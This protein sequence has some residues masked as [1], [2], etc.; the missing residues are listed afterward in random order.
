MFHWL[1]LLVRSSRKGHAV[2]ETALIAPWI[3]FLFVGILDFGFYA[4]GL[5]S[6][7]NAAR[8]A[9]LRAGSGGGTAN[10]QVLA[11]NLARQELRWMPNIKNLAAPYTCAS[12]PLK[13]DV[14]TNPGYTDAE[15]NPATWVQVTYQTVQLIPIPG[16]V[17]GRAT[18]SRRV[19]TRIFGG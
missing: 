3:F 7:Q 14:N 1:R 12:A 4:Y 6:V 17:T 10:D 15:G 5:I 18:I 2:V 8:V 9:A 13:V 19:E 16:L 11:C